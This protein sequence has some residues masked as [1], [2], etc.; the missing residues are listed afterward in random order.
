MS[1]SNNPSLLRRAGLWRTGFWSFAAFVLLA[2]AV[3][4]TFT[5]EVRWGLEDFAFAAVVLGITGTVLEAVLRRDDRIAYRAG[6]AIALATCFIIV[7]INAAVGIVGDSGNR[8]NLLYGGIIVLAMAGAIAA[9]FRARGMARAMLASAG[10]QALL[11]PLAWGE[12]GVVFGVVF[13]FTL[14]LT[15]L[16]LAAAACFARAASAARPPAG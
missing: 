3:A 13:C 15:V 1:L 10:A 6:A 7:W 12:A 16:W 2:P 8:A 9:R 11:L 14:A 5:Q 4:M